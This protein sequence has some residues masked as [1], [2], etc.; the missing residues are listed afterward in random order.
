MVKVLQK[1]HIIIWGECAMTHK[2][3]PKALNR[4]LKD[5]K[6]NDKLFDGAL[7][8]LSGNFRQTLPIIPRLMYTDEINACLK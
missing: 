4:T 2:H 6:S 1:C 7:I 5:L 3:S 8:L